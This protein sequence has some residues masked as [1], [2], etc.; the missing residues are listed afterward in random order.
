M[1][2]AKISEIFT[3]FQGEGMYVGLPQVFIRFYGCRLGCSFCDTPRNGFQWF[4]PAGLL[5]R[6]GEFPGHIHSFSLTGGEPLEQVDFLVEFLPLLEQRRRRIYL[7]TNGTLPGAL[8]RV[9]PWL[10]FVA[11]DIKLPSSTGRGPFWKEH[12]R[13]LQ[14]LGDSRLKSGRYFVK[15]VVCSSTL[16]E[17]MHEALSLISGVNPRIPVILQPNFAEL[18][19]KNLRDKLIYYHALSHKYLRHVRIIPQMHK[20]LGIQ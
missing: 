2:R 7:E 18:S 20:C 1:T 10:D 14:I 17:D 19:R 15:V 3:S 6:L 8:A 16:E 12:K 9:M 11:M 13:S 4:D 5:G